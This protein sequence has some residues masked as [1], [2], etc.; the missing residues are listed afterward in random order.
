MTQQHYNNQLFLQQVDQEVQRAR[1]KFPAGEANL[2]A[3]MEEV[4]EVAKAIMEESDQHVW[5]EAVQVAAVAMRVAQEG[6]PAH[7][8]VRQEGL[9]ER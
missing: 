4:G 6:D 7:S 1:A 3:L 2:A 8:H 9:D 5:D